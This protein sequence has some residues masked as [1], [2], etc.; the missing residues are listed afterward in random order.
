MAELAGLRRVSHKIRQSPYKSRDWKKRCKAPLFP[1]HR[2]GEKCVPIVGLLVLPC[3]FTLPGAFADAD[4]VARPIESA[5]QM[6][7][8][9]YIF[10]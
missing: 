9:L 4:S 5:G 2:G 8:N 3:Q 6:V 1:V 10:A 7:G